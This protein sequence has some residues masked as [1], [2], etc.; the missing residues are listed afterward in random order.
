METKKVY[1]IEDDWNESTICKTKESWLDSLRY[2]LD[3]CVEYEDCTL[4]QANEYYENMK[5]GAVKCDWVNAW[6]Y[7]VENVDVFYEDERVMLVSH[8]H[9]SGSKDVVSAYYFDG[10]EMSRTDM[11][12]GD[13]V[14]P[15]DDNLLESL[16][17]IIKKDNV[18]YDAIIKDLENYWEE[19]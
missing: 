19:K 5:N 3:V 11:N 13:C 1:L 14:T 17:K 2:N 18:D 16:K 15:Y 6:F 12:E 8:Y 7:S 4:E 9:Q 10:E